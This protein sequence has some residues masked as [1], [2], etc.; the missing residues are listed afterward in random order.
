MPLWFYIGLI[1]AISF[2]AW[3]TSLIL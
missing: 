1:V 2:I 3:G